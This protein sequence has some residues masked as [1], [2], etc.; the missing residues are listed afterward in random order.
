M[1]TVKLW[2]NI[3]LHVFRPFSPLFPEEDSPCLTKYWRDY[4]DQA[5]LTDLCFVRRLL[6]FILDKINLLTG[7]AQRRRPGRP[8][9]P[10]IQ[11]FVRNFKDFSKLVYLF[12]GL[13]FKLF[14]RF[15]D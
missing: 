9:P 13:K 2:D 10:H 3:F 8:C 12:F 14:Y 15:L 6:L 7:T 1:L 5:L 11:P 4:Q